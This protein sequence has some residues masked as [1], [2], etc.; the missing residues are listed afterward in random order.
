MAERFAV[1]GE[2]RGLGLSLAAVHPVRGFLPDLKFSLQGAG[3]TTVTQQAFAER[4]YRE[5]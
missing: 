4:F 2:V 5:P 1:I 3:G